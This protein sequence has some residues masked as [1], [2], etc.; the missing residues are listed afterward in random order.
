MFGKFKFLIKNQSRGNGPPVLFQVI[1]PK[2]GVFSTSNF[3]SSL[4]TMSVPDE[5][6]GL[7][8]AATD[9]QVTMYVRSSRPDQVLPVLEARY[10][11]IRFETVPASKD[12]LLMVGDSNIVCR[13]ILWPGGE[14]WLPLLIGDDDDEGD[15]FVDVVGGLSA[16]MPPGSRTV[17]RVVLSKRSNDWSEGWRHRTITG[18]GSENAKLE[19]ARRAEERKADASARAGGEGSQGTQN[20]QLLLLVAGLIFLSLGFFYRETLLAFWNENRVELIAFG[21]LALTALAGIGYLLRR[22]GVFSGP[23][24]P[25]YYDSEQVR[26]RVSRAAFRLEVQLYVMLGEVDAGAEAVERALRPV[27][28]AYHRFDNPVGTRFEAGPL[29]RLERFDPARDSLGFVGVRRDLLGR[30]TIGEGV[31]GTREAVALWHVP[32]DAVDAAKLVRAGS[33]RLPAPPE[34]FV[35]DDGARD[36][37]ALVGVE[38]YGDGGLRKMNFPPEVKSLHHL[39]VARTR[40]GKSTMMQNLALRLLRDKASG[41]SDATLVVV[42]PHTDLVRDILQGMPVGAA[43]D[44]RLIDMGDPARVCGVNLLDV[45]TFPKRDLVLPTIV[46][47]TKATSSHGSWGDRMEAILEWTLRTLYEANRHR[48]REEQYSILHALELLTDEGWRQEVIREGRNLD[49][50]QWWY[51]IYPA[52]VPGSDRTAI[53]PVLRKLGEYTGVDAARRV[54]GQRYCTLDIRE[55]IQTGKTLLVDTARARSGEA[56]SAIVGASVLKLLHDIIKEQSEVHPDRRRRIVVIVDEAQ[57]FPGVEYDDMLAELSKFGGSLILA[58]QSLDRLNDLTESGTMLETILANVGS[59]AA[60]QVNERDAERIR[61]EF[62]RA[63]IDEDDILNLQPHHC[64]GRLTLETGNVYYSMEVLPPLAGNGVVADLIR[65]ASDFYTRPTEDVDAEHDGFMQK[66]RRYFED[67][68]D[69]R[70]DFGSGR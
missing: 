33:R 46:S 65:R 15:P 60:F 54:L 17:T 14:E 20:M 6:L 59:L 47:I 58:T 13:Q 11:Q 29:E 55:A 21:V 64:Y 63:A 35:L 2:S 25:R 1:P 3:V 18:S 41:V 56:V 30:R 23:P 37:A 68:D 34:M 39:Y 36:R 22:L 12:P 28:A 51:S 8:L 52:L 42:D 5:E 27:V 10:P 67:Q 49:V 45:H 40:M 61:K 26:L 62:S 38:R 16:E 44:V 19:E 7:E 24:E 57:A 50:A 66:Y 31:V 48:E 69:D 70:F 9:G 4:E 32:G 53:A 43:G